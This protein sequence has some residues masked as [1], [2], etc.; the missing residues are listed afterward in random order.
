MLN[1]KLKSDR[2]ADFDFFCFAFHGAECKIAK[3]EAE[4]SLRKDLVNTNF[5]ASLDHSD[6]ISKS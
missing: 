2:P 1:R 5:S 3:Q 4:I 6:L